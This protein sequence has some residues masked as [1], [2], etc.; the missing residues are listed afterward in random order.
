MAAKKGWQDSLQ[1][2]SDQNAKLKVDLE[3]LERSK[4]DQIIKL[5]L[6]LE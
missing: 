6:Y 5:R 1:K 2:L 4:N 3:E